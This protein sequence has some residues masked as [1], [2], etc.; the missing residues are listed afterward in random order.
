VYKDVQA[1][2]KDER[3]LLENVLNNPIHRQNVISW[4]GLNQNATIIEN[5]D[6]SFFLQN[7]FN[8]IFK[9]L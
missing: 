1:A 9:N 5:E 7:N 4:F 3:I 2:L 6:I 8:A